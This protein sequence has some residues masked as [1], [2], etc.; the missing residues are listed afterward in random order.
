MINS[1]WRCDPSVNDEL[2]AQQLIKMKHMLSLRIPE[3]HQLDRGLCWTNPSG[4][5]GPGDKRGGG[6]A[7]G[8]K[9]SIYTYVEYTSAVWCHVRPEMIKV[10][11]VHIKSQTHEMCSLNL[12]R[13][14]QL[15]HEPKTS[16][17]TPSKD[18]KCVYT[19]WGQ[20][21]STEWI[22]FVVCF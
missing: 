15:F 4:A 11:T 2:L 19:S 14:P 7:G 3:P 17:Q 9:C 12:L 20:L 16:P 10:A 22:C 6:G 21:L 18:T 8:L 1:T 5:L 13:K